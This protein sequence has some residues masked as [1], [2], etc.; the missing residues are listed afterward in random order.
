MGGVSTTPRAYAGVLWLLTALFFLRVAG[1]ALVAFWS[2]PFLPPM[3]E[4]SSGLIPYPILLAVQIAMLAWMAAINT[5]IGRGARLSARP[6]F[7]L[8]LRRFA[9][10]YFAAMLLRYVASMALYPERRWLHGTIPIVFHWVLAGYLFTLGASHLRTR[11]A[12]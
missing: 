11:T 10:V 5:R 3:V 8:W 6:G 12:P 4:W 1:Q 9:V 7:A 2:A